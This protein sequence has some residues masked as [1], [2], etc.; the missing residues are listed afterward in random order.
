VDE[1]MIIELCRELIKEHAEKTGICICTDCVRNKAF[2]DGWDSRQPEIDEAK[3]IIND[4][5]NLLIRY[6]DHFRK[7]NKEASR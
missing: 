4:Q 6:S 2:R 3:K 7:I 1:K 5:N